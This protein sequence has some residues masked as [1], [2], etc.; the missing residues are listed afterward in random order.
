MFDHASVGSTTEDH[1]YT[2]NDIIGTD[3]TRGR[4]GRD[5]VPF[6]NKAPEEWY[7]LCEMSDKSVHGPDSDRQATRCKFAG[8]DAAIYDIFEILS[9]KLLIK[10]KGGNYSRR[11]DTLCGQWRDSWLLLEEVFL[12]ATRL[13]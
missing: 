12:R 6:L 13:Y 5:C 2:G 9:A 1:F 11:Y 10:A 8:H 3:S 7:L 4:F